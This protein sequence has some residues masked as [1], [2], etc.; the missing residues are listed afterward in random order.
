MS[1][2]PLMHPDLT[3]DDLL[4][5]FEELHSRERVA[6]HLGFSLSG[7]TARMKRLGIHK[8]PATCAPRK[9]SCLD[10]FH[11]QI[12]EL[13]AEGYTCPEIVDALALPVKEEQ[14]RRF[15]HKHGITLLAH[16]G[17]QPGEKHRDW[18]GGRIP[19]KNGY[20]LVHQPDHPYANSGGYVREHRLVMEQRLG[21]YL[22]PK[23]I[24]HHLNGDRADN[25]IENLELFASNGEHLAET[26]KGCVP[27]WSDEGKQR[28]VEG[29]RRARKLERRIG[30]NDHT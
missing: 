15:M 29:A 23:E 9:R 19:D 18:K 6:E 24:V 14:V 26:L 4:A 17:A 8:H 25:R 22:D 12:A 7:L 5:L 13:A 11:S 10:P 27:Q 30:Q 3:A 16:R 21:R 20:I 2:T 1:P 28:I